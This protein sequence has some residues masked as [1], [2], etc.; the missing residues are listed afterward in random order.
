MRPFPTFPG[1]LYFLWVHFYAILPPLART[2]VQSE[3]Q[4]KKT[5][6]HFSLQTARSE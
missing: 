2:A 6:E 3:H 1:C 4:Q 5:Q